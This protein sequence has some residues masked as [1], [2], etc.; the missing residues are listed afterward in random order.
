MPDHGPGQQAQQDACQ[1]RR[2]LR[3]S[4]ATHRPGVDEHAL[5]RRT[6][7]RPGAPS[8]R[9]H[10][11]P[12]LRA[13]PRRLCLVRHRVSLGSSPSPVPT[14]RPRA[15]RGRSTAA[16]TLHRP[17]AVWV[18]AA[19]WSVIVRCATRR[20]DQRR[21][22]IRMRVA[23]EC[24]SRTVARWSARSR[25][26]ACRSS[27]TWSLPRSASRRLPVWAGRAEPE[28]SAGASSGRSGVARPGSR[29]GAVPGTRASARSAGESGLI[30][31]P[32]R[33]AVV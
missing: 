6:A 22:S 31:P 20:P 14:I 28:R 2:P 21:T 25:R 27:R 8:L 17:L 18:G 9:L 5:A 11:R 1:H 19:A 32:Y 23:A 30:R 16:Q 24:R 33:A 4:P 26:A 12:V 13:F 15:G 10:D 7:P 29:C 3:G